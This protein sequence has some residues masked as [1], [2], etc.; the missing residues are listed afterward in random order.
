[1]SKPKFFLPIP[2]LLSLSGRISRLQYFVYG[3]IYTAIFLGAYVGFYAVASNASDVTE[4]VGAWIYAII[5]AGFLYALVCN[6]GKRLHDL[7]SPAILCVFALF[8]L[9]LDIGVTLASAYV[10]IPEAVLKVNE[11]SGNIGNVVAIGFGLILTFMPG[12]RGS[13]K[14]GPDPLQAPRP[15]VS[16]F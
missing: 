12:Q 7:G 10:A 8:D 9:P 15:E 3:L 5:M 4:P 1:M 11:I 13:N 16:V 6:Y 14:Y 2:V